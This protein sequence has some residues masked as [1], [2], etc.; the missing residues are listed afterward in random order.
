MKKNALNVEHFRYHIT[1]NYDNSNISLIFII[2]T[3]AV[4]QLI[5]SKINVFVYIIYVYCVYL[6]CIYKDTHMQH[7]L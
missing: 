4:K 5:S 7:I 6:L 2:L 3:S 1:I